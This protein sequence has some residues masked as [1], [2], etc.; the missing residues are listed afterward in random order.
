[1]CLLLIYQ[2]ININHIFWTNSYFVK[3]YPVHSIL[4]WK[5]FRRYS[6]VLSSTQIHFNT[7]ILIDHAVNFCPYSLRSVVVWFT[8]L[9]GGVDFISYF[10]KI[11]YWK[12]SIH[13]LHSHFDSICKLVKLN[14]T[15]LPRGRVQNIRMYRMYRMYIGVW[16]VDSQQS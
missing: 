3:F 10:V 4:W 11:L 16:T 13:I 14:F 9:V 15:R 2:N 5:V 8:V 6:H 1:M 7:F 12:V